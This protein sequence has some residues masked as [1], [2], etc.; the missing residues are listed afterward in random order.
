MSETK[1]LYI[2][3]DMK[4][5]RA[6]WLEY[7]QGQTRL[8]DNQVG[9]MKAWPLYLFHALIMQKDLSEWIDIDSIVIKDYIVQ[10]IR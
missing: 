8:L 1:H 3:Y 5:F 2:S 6:V 9:A 7:Q 10:L 4:Y